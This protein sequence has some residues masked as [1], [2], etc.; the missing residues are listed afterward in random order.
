[1][2]V[3]I[4]FTDIRSRKLLTILNAV[5]RSEQAKLNKEGLDPITGKKSQENI[6]SSS[7]D[8]NGIINDSSGTADAAYSELFIDLPDRQEDQEALLEWAYFEATALVK[9]YGELL[10]EVKDYLGTR[11][12]TVGE[13]VFLIE[14]ELGG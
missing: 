7:N 11:T 5:Q 8:N 2:C 4:V 3:L 1:M 13:C 12:T 10:E 9:Q 6:N 14:E